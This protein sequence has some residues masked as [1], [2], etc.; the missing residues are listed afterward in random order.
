MG[1]SRITRRVAQVT[2]FVAAVGVGAA[3]GQ[4]LQHRAHQP[5]QPAVT[6]QAFSE[7]S[8]RSAKTDRMEVLKFDSPRLILL[9]DSECAICGSVRPVWERLADRLPDEVS[10]DA[11]TCEVRGQS[12]KLFTTDRVSVW[13]YEG[14]DKRVFGVDY[15][16]ATL[17]VAAGGAVVWARVGQLTN[18]DLETIVGLVSG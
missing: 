12:M 15:V 13:H 5:S 11:I 16:P 4:W 6:V 8:L 18:R 3:V 10:V 7:L 14:A 9:F 1:R 2:A 17:L